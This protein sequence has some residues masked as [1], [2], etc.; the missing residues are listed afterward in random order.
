MSQKFLAAAFL[1]SP[2]KHPI[3]SLKSG[4]Y[5]GKFFCEG[6]LKN[7]RPVWSVVTR[8]VDAVKAQNRSYTLKGNG[9][10]DF[11][12]NSGTGRAAI[13]INLCEERGE[14]RLL[15]VFF[16]ICSGNVQFF[17]EAI[18]LAAFDAKDFCSG[19]FTPTG[20]FEGLGNNFTLHLVKGK[21]LVRRIRSRL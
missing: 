6:L 5:C 21:E 12:A 15:S 17:E 19:D 7:N 16:F 13:Y 11:T 20:K 14:K 10:I 3:W 18:K 8:L 2:V 1:F 9:D 4:N